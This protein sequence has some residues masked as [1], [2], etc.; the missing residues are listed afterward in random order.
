MGTGDL[1]DFLRARRARLSP[2]Q[3]GIPRHGSRRVPGLRREEVAVLAG[4]SVDYYTRLEQGRERAP[5]AQVVDALSRALGLD[6][7]GR[8]HLLRLA[9]LAAPFGAC[10]PGE[11]VS[12]ALRRLLDSHHGQPAF[13]LD[14][15]FDFLAANDL[16]VALFSP[17]AAMDNLLNM[18]FLDPAARAFFADWPGAAQNAVANL[19]ANISASPPNAWVDAMVDR[20]L[21]GSA[22]FA[23]IW[24]AHDVR[25]KAHTAK[26][27][28]HPRV[29]DLTLDLLAF[30]V[31]GAPGQQLIVYQAEPGGPT[32]DALAVL[33]SL[34]ATRMR[35]APPR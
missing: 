35:A 10:A 12:P 3:A 24:R 33:G 11:Q 25:G 13:V 26:R 23:R 18:I 5:S 15:S 14:L 1:G 9:G 16:A 32:A 8:A 4:V 27:F 2:E 30:D 20:L 34:H 28:R 29:G 6:E 7:D 31:R 22:E 21:A 19:R 17:F